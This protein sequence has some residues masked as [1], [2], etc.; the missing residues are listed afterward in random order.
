MKVAEHREGLARVEARLDRI[1]VELRT[2]RWMIGANTALIL[3]A[4]GRLFTL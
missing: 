2:L 4:L 3:V 1:E